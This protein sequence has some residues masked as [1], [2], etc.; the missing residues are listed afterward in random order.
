VLIRQASNATD[1]KTGEGLV[2]TVTFNDNEARMI[3]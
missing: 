1:G 3:E 2:V